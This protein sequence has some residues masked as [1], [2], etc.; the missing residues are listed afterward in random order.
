MSTGILLKEIDKDLKDP[1]DLTDLTSQ[2]K[3]TESTINNNLT[4]NIPNNKRIKK[5]V[6]QFRN[7]AGINKNYSKLVELV[8]ELIPDNLEIKSE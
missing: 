7:E 6:L 5:V 2:T 3:Q 8:S 1:K 4:L